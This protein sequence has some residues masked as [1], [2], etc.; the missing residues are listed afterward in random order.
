MAIEVNL[1][2]R[3]VAANEFQIVEQLGPAEAKSDSSTPAVRPA[4]D[5]VVPSGSSTIAPGMSIVVSW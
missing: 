2:A 3:F 1:Q 5:R 4:A